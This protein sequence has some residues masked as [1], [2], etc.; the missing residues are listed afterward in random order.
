MEPG[1]LRYVF[2]TKGR[3]THAPYRESFFDIGTRSCGFWYIGQK[4]SGEVKKLEVEETDIYTL[5][6]R[7]TLHDL[8]FQ[9]FRQKHIA[10]QRRTF[11]IPTFH[12]I[13]THLIGFLVL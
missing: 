1:D 13:K 3:L 4:R 12:A 2:W 9:S 8:A 6:E 11:W 5:D 7:R 10:R